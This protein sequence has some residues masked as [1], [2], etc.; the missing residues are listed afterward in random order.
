MLQLIT[1]FDV[2]TNAQWLRVLRT[3]MLLQQLSGLADGP[4][5]DTLLEALDR[6]VSSA[7]EQSM[8]RAGRLKPLG[9]PLW[10]DDSGLAGACGG[11][12]RN[13]W[14][15]GWKNHASSHADYCDSG[16]AWESLTAIHGEGI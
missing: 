6:G 7:A 11:Q 10:P 8:T 2:L 16:A 1:Q 3:V 9:I 12:P 14:A 15:E 13:R 4:G 5:L